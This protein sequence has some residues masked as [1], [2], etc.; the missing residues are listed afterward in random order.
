M[1]EIVEHGLAH[2]VRMHRRDT[3]DAVRADEGELA[4]AD[5]AA[6]PLVDQRDRG[7]EVDVA[8]RTRFGERQM[9][10]VDAVDD[11]EMPRQQ[12]FEQ[13]D[14]PGLQ[15]LGQQ[16]VVGVGQRRDRDL[17]RLVP[18][19][20]V[21][22]DQDPHQ[23][24]DGEARMGVVELHR[25]LGRQAA[26]LAVRRKMPLDQILE[27]GRDEEIFLAQAQLAPRRALVIRI[28]E[29]AD[30][31]RARLLG[32]GADIVALVEGVEL[33]GIG[34]ARRPQPERIDVLAAPAD[35]RRV[36]GERLHGLGRMP[37]RAVAAL[38]VDMLD[39]AAEIDVVDHFRPLQFPGIAKAEPFV[40]IFLLPALVDDLAE[41]AVIITDAVADCRDRQ[42]RHALH[43]AGGEAPE[44]AIAECR[45]RLAF[46]QLRQRDAEI[47]E[48]DLEDLQQPH[49]VQRVGE[50]AT[51]Q[52]FQREI[53]DALASGVV[54]ALLGGEPAMHDAVA[55]RECGGLI[56]VVLGRHARVLADGKA[57]L[58]QDRALDFS[59]REFVDGLTGSR[60][61]WLERLILQGRTSWSREHH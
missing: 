42:R 33:Q 47:A 9:L 14:R 28:E 25:D 10:H 8:R 57:Q 55:Q 39:A 3:V 34:R 50:E 27:R 29:F 13:L 22:V 36:I 2:Q 43:E 7:A 24:G 32:A 40:R 4:H 58:R 15:R 44:A 35:D 61:I 60:E 46:A 41:Q 56:P 18:A 1:V 31:F 12:P 37:D 38:V 11:L 53:I 49:I 20:I 59:Q 54:A 21:Q 26:E 16:R 45:I 52:E 5:A 51:D 23:L 17:P 48:R 30:R 19:E 6:A